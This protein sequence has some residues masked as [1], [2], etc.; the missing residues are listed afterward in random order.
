M[1]H[2][3]DHL[4]TGIHAKIRMHAIEGANLQLMAL[5]SNSGMH[6][7]IEVAL[8]RGQVSA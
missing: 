1:C 6:E 4:H 5:L 3:P 7:F 8:T 2:E